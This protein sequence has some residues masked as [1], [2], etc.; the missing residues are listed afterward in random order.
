MKVNEFARQLGIVSSKVRYYDR[1]GLIQG[2]R[3]DNNYRNFT[4]QD[5]LNMYHA[6][7][8]RSFDMSIQESLNAKNEELDQIDEWVGAHA[9]SLEEQI[10]W[11]E[12]KLLRLKE[13]Q[14]YF[15]M[16]K[17]GRE[18]VAQFSRDNSYNVWN[19]GFGAVRTPG[20]QKAVEILSEN[21][22]FSYIAIKIGLQSV[23]E[24]RRPLDVS[25]GL[26]ILERNK[27]KLDLK[28]PAEVERKEG[29]EIL[30]YMLEVSDPFQLTCQDLRPL[31]EEC[32]RRGK[33]IGQDL[34]GRIYLSYMKNGV[35][36]HGIGLA[37]EI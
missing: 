5:A 37:G 20:V 11:Q 30:Q 35:F 24:D 6:Q 26:G 17:E 2:E 1:M 18:R 8:L 34:I 19:F 25:I 23:L 13:M 4:P 31:L 21:M 14:A 28:L 36:V 7:M 27:K 3:Q 33:P 32:Q 10:R 15:Q 12:I 22:P 29:G 16:I 9:E